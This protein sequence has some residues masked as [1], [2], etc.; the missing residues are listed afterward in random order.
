M[1][2]HPTMA[3][4]MPVHLLASSF[5]VSTRRDTYGRSIF[6]MI[7]MSMNSP[8][9]SQTTRERLENELRRAVFPSSGALP[10]SCVKRMKIP[11][12]KYMA[13]QDQ[14]ATL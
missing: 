4:M 13:P 6:R 3:L 7:D 12:R 14:N 11:P 10:G 2:L 9:I 5:S 1:E 8:M